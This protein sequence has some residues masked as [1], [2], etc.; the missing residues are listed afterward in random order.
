M[1][2]TK[3]NIKIGRERDWVSINVLIGIPVGNAESKS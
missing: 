2:Q 1:A 3:P